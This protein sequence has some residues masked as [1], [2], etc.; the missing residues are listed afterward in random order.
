[1]SWRRNILH[2][3]ESHWRRLLLT[4]HSHLKKEKKRKK[5]LT[6]APKENFRSEFAS[7]SARRASVPLTP[8]LLIEAQINQTQAC[9]A[10]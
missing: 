3:L 10:Y 8:L 4:H 2:T 7:S 6:F 1:M 5:T 9:A